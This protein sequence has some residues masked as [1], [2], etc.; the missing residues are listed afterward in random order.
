MKTASM[1]RFAALACVSVF[2]LS[3]GACGGGG[4]GSGSTT[5]GG[6]TSGGTGGGT[7]GGTGGGTSGGSGG[8]SG[9]GTSD[10]TTLEYFYGQGSATG[11]YAIDPGVPTS[12]I[13]VTSD[14]VSDPMGPVPVIAGTLSNATI[15]GEHVARVVY[16]DSSGRLW[17]VTT[18]P[19]VGTPT[20]ERVS[21]AQVSTTVCSLRVGNDLADTDNVRIAYAVQ[22][23]SDCSSGKDWK[24]TRVGDGASIAPDDFPGAPIVGLVD[25][26]DGG[27]SGW[28]T[29]EGG[30]VEL[31]A[32]DLT[33]TDLGVSGVKSADY[34]ES[35]LDGT[36]FLN[37]DGALYTYQQQTK[38]LSA[39][40]GFSFNSGL[41]PVAAVTDG[42]DLYFVDARKLYRAD[43]VAG[44]VSVISDPADSASLGLMGSERLTVTP[45]YV[46]WAYGRDTTPSD[47]NPFADVAHVQ[48]I[49]KSSL[50]KTE[51]DDVTMPYGF[52]QGIFDRTGGWFFY[53]TTDGSGNVNAVAYKADGSDKKVYQDAQWTGASL[54]L[55]QLGDM[56]ASIEIAYML[57]GVTLNQT[58]LSGVAVKSVTG[59]APETTPRNLGSLP[60]GVNG[61]F[62]FGG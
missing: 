41:D 2:A 32:P 48:S 19:N 3:L 51:G 43:P 61:F 15:T 55:G 54:K 36:V 40:D 33:V 34:F 27:H 13:T 24:V 30:T 57:S 59:N 39:V 10:V 50:A 18:D 29:L 45:N 47:G 44:T 8:G 1:R 11:L 62:P 35:L 14:V 20:P 56:G 37:I 4:G 28:L 49:N 22:T 25:P 42:E 23:G 17:Q 26:A 58:D 31:V 5:T 53:T 12:T 9:G 7:T 38:T 21:S 52:N 60:S 46:V 6:G 16:P